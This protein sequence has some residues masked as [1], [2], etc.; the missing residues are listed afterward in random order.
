MTSPKRILDCVSTPADL[1]LL[2]VDELEILA[3][4]IRSQIIA[5]T[6]KTGGHVASSLG[7]VEI[8]L[9]CHSVLNVPHDKLVFDVGH[10]SYAHKLVTGR[11]SQFDT[12]RTY[13]G[14]SGFPKPSESPYDAHTSG[15]ASD[16]LSVASG[17]AKANVLNNADNY[18]VSVIGDASLAGGMAFEALN[19]IGS[20]QL[21]MVIILNDNEMSISHNVG[22]LMRHLGNMRTT[23]VY[24]NARDTI[25]ERMESGGW[26]SNAFAEWGKRIKE[27][28]KHMIIPD[29]M[30]YEQLGIVCT[31]PINGNNIADLQEMLRL[32]LPMK[33][34]VL[35]HAVTKK[36][37]GYEPAERD[38]VR[39]HGIGPY[40]PETGAQAASSLDDLQYT[41][42][43]SNALLEEA[44]KDDAIV[45]IT[46][47]MEEG[48]GLAA[49]HHAF[50]SRFIDVGIAE[51]QAVGM[52]A[53]LAFAGMK[54]VVAVYSTFLQR[55]LDQL[56]VDV[57]LPHQN[58][59]FA[60]DRAG[61]VGCDG[62]T[63]HGAFD[64]ALLRPV[65]NMRI[66]VPS[67][68]EEL[69]NALH[70]ALCLEGP[71][72]IRY[73]RGTA[74][75]PPS[76]NPVVLEE[77]KAHKVVDGTDAAILAWGRMVG[78]AKEAAETLKARGVSVLVYDMR[79]AKP[80]D[81]EAVVN[82]AHTGFVI[83]IE[84]GSVIGGA[85]AGVLE[86]LA[87]HE[88]TPRVSVLGLPDSFVA[89]GNTE[90]LLED[91]G[92]SVQSILK[93]FS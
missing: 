11:L 74:C 34:P 39:F 23:G 48:T 38:P 72:A 1:H 56:I 25:Q 61:I 67:D 7:A 41:A 33:C 89:Q 16:S 54:P 26:V 46:A 75:N 36:G 53:G 6:S 82:A 18:V 85:G 52:A 60:L 88:L 10:Q 62:P 49:F 44:K 83:T 31:P 63:H 4:E 93:L 17:Y 35:I 69:Q 66:L 27:S 43:F 68:A 50:P 8:I 55:A 79:W 30:I 40:D 22:A 47:A 13:G 32:V 59:V 14:I 21:P 20:Q 9:A 65:P 15:H 58:V 64:I 92:L 78:V 71:V 29:S 76:G 42:V 87:Q 3:S 70:T 45:A 84:E 91:A 12:L 77:G 51:E 19:Y 2:S 81:R 80:I 73:P 28:T 5:T 86:I 37:V 90:Q 24:R 57:A